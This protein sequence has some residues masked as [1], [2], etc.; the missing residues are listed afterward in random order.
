MKFKLKTKNILLE[1]IDSQTYRK[2]FQNSIP[3]NEDGLFPIILTNM[4]K[5][6]HPEIIY[7]HYYM[8]LKGLFGKSSR[9]YDDYKSSFGYIFL[10][11]ISDSL[12]TLNF[13]DMKGVLTFDLKKILTTKDEFERYGDMKKVYQEPFNEFSNDDIKEFMTQFIGYIVG[14]IEVV[15]DF[16]NEE[17]VRLLNYRLLIYGYKDGDFFMKQ[18]DY[19]DEDAEEE[20]YK[21]RK[22]LMSKKSSKLEYKTT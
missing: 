4:I 6:E 10:L 11:K 21:E 16:Y 18:Y 13:N 8:A 17:F 1:T 9:L 19:S 20:F 7:P 15:K 12:Y 14:Y 5:K 2:Y 22:K 3:I